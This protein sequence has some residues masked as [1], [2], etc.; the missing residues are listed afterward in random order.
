[1]PHTDEIDACAY[2]FLEEIGEPS[3]SDLRL[4]I[5]EA[6]SGGA[7]SPNDDEPGWSWREGRWQVD[8]DA[9]GGRFHAARTRLR[10]VARLR[11]FLASEGLPEREDGFRERSLA[12]PSAPVP[13]LH[14][15]PVP[16]APP[17]PPAAP[18][19]AGRAAA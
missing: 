2:L 14:S 17:G 15:K 12:D 6:K 8:F 1:M 9:D 5:V 18:C 16:G 13:P 19:S 4:K 3:D 11:R 7:A 10:K